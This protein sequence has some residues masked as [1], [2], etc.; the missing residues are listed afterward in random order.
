MDKKLYAVQKFKDAPDGSLVFVWGKGF[1]SNKIR[2]FQK[3]ECNTDCKKIFKKLSIE[4]DFTFPTHV[5][6]KVSSKSC[7][8]AE[9]YGVDEVEFSRHLEKGDIKLCLASPILKEKDEYWQTQ[10]ITWLK[11][12]VGMKYDFHGFLSF[13]DR[14]L[15][16]FG[17]DLMKST[18]WKESWFCSELCAKSYKFWG[19]DE[20]VTVLEPASKISPRELYL[21]CVDSK[22]MNVEMIY[23][24]G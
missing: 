16:K 14:V 24:D 20:L 7:V 8:S 18:H 9:F 23:G 1:V 22:R 13:I 19:G 15:N 5:E 2:F 11:D 12:Q 4:H 6:S 17:I 3:Y 10:A 21:R